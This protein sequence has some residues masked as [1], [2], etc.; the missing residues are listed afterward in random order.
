MV[1][2]LRLVVGLCFCICVLIPRNI[3]FVCQFVGGVDFE[4]W[5][6]IKSVVQEKTIFLSLPSGIVGAKSCLFSFRGQQSD[7]WCLFLLTASFR[8]PSKNLLCL[9]IW[10]CLINLMSFDA[11]FIHFSR[12][13]LR[14]SFSPFHRMHAYLQIS[15]PSYIVSPENS[16]KTAHNKRG[17][18]N[19]CVSS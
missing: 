6:L 15:A 7:P 19:L 4:V 13:Q 8:Y 3:G 16:F 18:N 9:D 11:P 12:K 14:V 1:S 10:L 2:L 17:N 5:D